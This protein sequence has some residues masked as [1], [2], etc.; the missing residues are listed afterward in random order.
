MD[1]TKTPRLILRF[2]VILLWILSN[3]WVQP[4]T[5]TSL[6]HHQNATLALIYQDNF[7]DGDYTT[8]DGPTGLTWSLLAGGASVDD[9]DGSLQLG[10]D[11]GYTLIA[12]N[13]TVAGDEYTLRFAGRIT[14]S[15][16]GR[17]VVL[18]K[19]T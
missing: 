2:L 14:W 8:A 10:V 12:T 18:Y 16:P 4:A 13:Q 6:S 3:L 17:V 19:K 15:A 11:R 9:V 1:R 7:E 5:S